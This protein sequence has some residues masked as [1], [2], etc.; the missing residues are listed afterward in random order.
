MLASTLQPRASVL[1]AGFPEVLHY[2]Y[3][4]PVGDMTVARAAGRPTITRSTRVI[5]VLGSAVLGGTFGFVIGVGMLAI[6]AW[7]GAVD[8]DPTTGGPID[9]VLLLV[10]PAI[11]VV[12]GIR[13]CIASSVA[14]ARLTRTQHKP[15]LCK[16][17]GYPIW[18]LADLR[19]PECGCAV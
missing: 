15:G 4:F 16:S 3:W 5:M 19:C 14:C 7:S 17:C 18:R 6:I 10:W 1:P 13:L 12:F 11:P 8:F 2:R 9:L